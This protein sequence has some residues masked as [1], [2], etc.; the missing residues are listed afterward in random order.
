M[1]STYPFPARPRT[2]GKKENVK[3][4]ASA[5][6]LKTIN[7]SE[8]LKPFSKFYSL[9]FLNNLQSLSDEKVTGETYRQ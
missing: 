1:N 7:F 5:T 6:T 3:R 2:P 9:K 4:E 8:Q